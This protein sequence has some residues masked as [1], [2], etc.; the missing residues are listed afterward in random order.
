MTA[1]SSRCARF[2]F[3]LGCLGLSGIALAQAPGAAPSLSADDLARAQNPVWM[4]GA[5]LDRVDGE[6]WAA[7]P[8]YKAHF[9][10]G[11]VEIT[12]PLGQDAP[13]SL[14]LVFALESIDL[15]ATRVLTASGAVEPVQDGQ[16][17]RYVHGGGIVE[18]YDARVDGLEQSFV[19]D[20]RPQ[21]AGDL[22]VRGRASTELVPE[23]KGAGL[24]FR[25]AGLDG[26]RGLEY[27]GVTGIDANGRRMPGSV[28]WL[29]DAIELRLPAAFVATAAFPLTIDPVIGGTFSVANQ[30]NTFFAD[31]DVAFHLATPTYLVTFERVWSA[32]DFD[33]YAQ[34]VSVEGNLVGA[35]ILLETSIFNLA[36]NPTVA[37]CSPSGSFLVAWQQSS[38]VNGPFDLVAKSV[39]A[40]TGLQSLPVTLNTVAAGSTIDPDAGGSAVGA[41]ASVFVF[42]TQLGANPGIHYARVDVPASGAPS[43]NGKYQLSADPNDSKPTVSKYR[44]NAHLVAWQRFYSTPAPGDHDLFHAVVGT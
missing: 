41:A 23:A 26:D 28:T 42:W 8:G 16:S 36:L 37:I 25:A 39:S 5:G 12:P 6:L 7:G 9:R 2:A 20:E 24:F 43:L 30:F 10:S 38:N 29:G 27:G 3:V 35:Q 44:L 15:G 34:R 13:R 22:V 17:A 21:G 40:S 14:P 32:T 19:L 33:V 1:A 11:S 31:P 18:R 4:R